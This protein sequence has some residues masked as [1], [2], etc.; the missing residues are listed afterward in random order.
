MKNK[1]L[2]CKSIEVVHTQN[3]ITLIALIITVIV[4]LI[5]AGVAIY[6]INSAGLFGKV[7]QATDVWNNSVNKEQNDLDNLLDIFD[8]IARGILVEELSLNVDILD[9]SKGHT[10]QL[11]PTIL[12]EDAT[13]KNVTWTTSDSS[14]V[15][16]DNNGIVAINALAV[17]G[18]SAIITCTATDGSG[19]TATCEVIV[20]NPPLVPVASIDIT[21]EKR[22]P[23]EGTIILTEVV[24][25]GT[26]TNKG[27]IWS[28]SPTSIATIDQTGK[29]TGVS[30]GEVTITCTAKDGSGEKA[31]YT[32]EVYPTKVAH[33]KKGDYVD[34]WVSNKT[35]TIPATQTGDDY[36]AGDQT[37]NTGDYHG[38]WKIW[39]ANHPTYGVQ[40]ISEGS[41]TENSN[42]PSNLFW[43]RGLDGYNNMVE[44]LNSMCG[45]YIN[46]T[47]SLNADSGRCL[48]SLPTNNKNSPGFTDYYINENPYFEPYN[49]Q[50]RNIDPYYSIDGSH[51]AVNMEDR[52]TVRVWLASRQ[53]YIVA[54]VEEDPERPNG[55]YM[56]AWFINLNNTG[57]RYQGMIA[58]WKVYENETIVST[59]VGRRSSSGNKH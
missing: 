53:V 17:A 14:K 28:A 41:V 47:Y 24:S 25:P 12:P 58:M 18:E 52:T 15:T 35:Y 29:I 7:N 3:G 36:L 45:N 51:T 34:Y 13:N 57:T 42:T 5:L 2:T 26:A 39:W 43:I 16:V 32:V 55:V 50:V 23:V 54:N 31:T 37:F 6:S 20:V 46:T 21:G 40:I 8:D 4:M 49:G 1:R 59:S 44:V 19:L 33:L 48:G 30:Y 10:Y 22:V 38:N 56:S 9:L 27:V 11:I